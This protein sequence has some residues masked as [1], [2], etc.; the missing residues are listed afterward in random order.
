[1]GKT[2]IRSV[3]T[4]PLLRPASTGGKASWTFAIL[5]AEVSA[6]LPRR[7]RTSV[8][9]TVNGEPFQTV[10]EPDGQLG[11][12][13]KLDASLMCAA[14][15]S[16]GDTV[17]FELQPMATQL[18]PTLPSAFSK[19]LAASP[20]ARATWD[21]TTT[22]ARMDWVH[23]MESAKQASTR[24]K[25]VADAVQMLA[26]GKKRVCCFDA[27]GHYDRSLAAPEAVE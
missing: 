23:W 22:L 11:H 6:T 19:A 4:A 12:W 26:N 3:F 10:L 1:M 17:T 9:G 16:A 5:P 27:S 18:E 8:E 15:V 2:R 24:D 25:R 7:G 14:D 20:G 13:L 21:A